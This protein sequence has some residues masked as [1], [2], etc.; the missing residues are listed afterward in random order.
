MFQ[1]TKLTQNEIKGITYI[2]GGLLAYF[3][4]IRPIF[5]SLNIIENK[6]STNVNNTISTINN[7]FDIN[8]WTQYNG[9]KIPNDSI[10]MAAIA[11]NIYSYFNF[12]NYTN[13]WALTLGAFKNITN[14]ASNSYMCYCFNEKYGRDLLAYL[15]SPNSILP[16]AGLSTTHIDNIINYVNSLPKY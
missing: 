15:E 2:G 11:D 6:E 12:T 3:L 8:F 5:Q 14:Q 7:P 13:S 1:K 4:V 10:D 9:G 16:G